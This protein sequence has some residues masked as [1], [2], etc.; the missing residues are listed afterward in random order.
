M[1]PINQYYC[2][3]DYTG[4]LVCKNITIMIYLNLDYKQC[5][6]IK[7]KQYSK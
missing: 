1:K 5:K 2:G 3:G 7:K 4:E 6:Y